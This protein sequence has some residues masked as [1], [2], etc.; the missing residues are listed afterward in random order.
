MSDDSQNELGKRFEDRISPEPPS[1]SSASDS[2]NAS[3]TEEMNNPGLAS[4]TEN[5]SNSNN[6]GNPSNTGSSPGPDP[7]PN[8]SRNQE[9]IYMAVGSDRADALNGMYERFDARSKLAGQGGIEKHRDFW[10][11]AA[12]LLIDSEDEL[13]DRLDIPSVTESE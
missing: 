7:D 2:S 8:A 13:A 11:A 3:T 1:S 4:E 6:S 9:R 5:A 10:A 12:E